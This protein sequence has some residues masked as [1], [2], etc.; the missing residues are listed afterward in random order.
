VRSKLQ[1]RGHE[2]FTPTLTGVSERCHLLIPQVNEMHCADVINLI[3]WEELTNLVLCG[4]SYGDAQLAIS[5]EPSAAA[6]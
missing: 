1:A 4:H 3:P 5:P 2:V 6:A